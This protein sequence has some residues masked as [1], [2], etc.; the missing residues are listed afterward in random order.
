MLR[1]V[2]RLDLEEDFVLSDISG[3]SPRPFTITKE[4]IH[5]DGTITFI[6]SADDRIDEI[7]ERLE[8]SPAVHEVTMVSDTEL[9]VRKQTSGALPIVQNNN[10]LLFKWIQFHGTER[11]F[12]ILVYRRKDLQ[13]IIT[14]FE[15]I[16][17][18]HLE[19]IEPFSKEQTKLSRRQAEV[20]TVALEEGY[21]DWPRRIEAK[22]LAD[23]LD[24]SH[25]T[26]LEH[27]RKAE[28]KII[29]QVLTGE[30]G[31]DMVG[32]DVPINNSSISRPTTSTDGVVADK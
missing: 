29:E 21:F 11:I 13:R 10:G 25:P 4:E 26:M 17:R 28:K 31:E 22:D 32:S 7:R 20:I 2:I 27:L 5:N 14:E 24:I 15:E 30:Q 3:D 9:L 23:L 12:D 19:K 1:C 16:G 18:P 8:T 6:F